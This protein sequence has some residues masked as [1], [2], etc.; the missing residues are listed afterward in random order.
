[1]EELL[2]APEAVL[3]TDAF[4]I[5]R[6][7]VLHCGAEIEA[8]TK[9]PARLLQLLFFVNKATRM[10]LGI[11]SEWGAM[12]TPSLELHSSSIFS[13]YEVHKTAVE[14]R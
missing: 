8:L 13:G 12:N 5:S 7:L 2:L 4:N 9:A 10:L 14:Y 11:K 6:S 3:Q 1:M